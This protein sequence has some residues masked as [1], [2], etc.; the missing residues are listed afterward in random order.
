MNDAIKTV[1]EAVLEY[2]VPPT[3]LQDRVTDVHGPQHGR[4]THLHPDEEE[5]LVEHIKL[6]ADWGFPRTQVDV[7]MFVKSYLEKAGIT[8][9]FT[10][11]LPTVRHMDSLLQCYQ[12]LRL[13]KTSLIKKRKAAVSREEVTEFIKH[14][15]A[16]AE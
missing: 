12:D 8:S 4:P 16:T 10:K 3:T 14:L 11:I 6:L 7:T 1:K 5:L 9:K 15:A 13:R 2:G